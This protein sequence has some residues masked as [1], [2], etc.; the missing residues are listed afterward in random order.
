MGRPSGHGRAG[1]VSL[2]ILNEGTWWG[3][4]SKATVGGALQRKAGFVFGGVPVWRRCFL[5]KGM[6][7][8]KLAEKEIEF[9]LSSTLQ[10]VAL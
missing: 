9:Q 10:A 4:Q 1:H 6:S 5:I 7:L 2:M 3:G 8:T